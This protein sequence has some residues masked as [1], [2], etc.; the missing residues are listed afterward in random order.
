MNSATSLQE[1]GCLSDTQQLDVTHAALQLAFQ[2]VAEQAEVL[3]GEM[4]GGVLLDRGGPDALRL[5][6]TVLRVSTREAA[7]AQPLDIAN[8]TVAGNA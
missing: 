3:A 5:L 1:W 7:P 2:T 8:L 4:E 6:A